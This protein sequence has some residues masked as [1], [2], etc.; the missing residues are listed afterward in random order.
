MRLA[1]APSL[2]PRAG[3]LVINEFISMWTLMVIRQRAE[4]FR[5]RSIGLSLIVR[6]PVLPKGGNYDSLGLNR[7]SCSDARALHDSTLC[8]S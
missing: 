6:H 5:A 8:R 3:T 4:P 1:F 2:L 7:P